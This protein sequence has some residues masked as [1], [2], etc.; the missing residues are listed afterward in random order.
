MHNLD[1]WY[2]NQIKV[3]K[4]LAHNWQC[5]FYITLNKIK[6][7]YKPNNQIHSGHYILSKFHRMPNNL[8][9]IQNFVTSHVSCSTL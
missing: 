8:N 9:L 7:I 4:C 5:K 3:H 1:K 2:F 6:D